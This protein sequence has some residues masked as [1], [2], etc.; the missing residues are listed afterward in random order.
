MKKNYMTLQRVTKD[1]EF[2]RNVICDLGGRKNQPLRSRLKR[3]ILKMNSIKSNGHSL[4]MTFIPTNRKKLGK[5][6]AKWSLVPSPIEKVLSAETLIP[7]QQRQDQ[8]QLQQLQSISN[9]KL[10]VTGFDVGV[11]NAVAWSSIRPDGNVSFGTASS[12]GFYNQV[13]QLFTLDKF[14]LFH[15]TRSFKVFQVF[16]LEAT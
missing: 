14:T 2:F 13:I 10:T 8:L 12:K 7:K 15:Q 5:F 3:G 16:R 11:V 1:G 6:E 9:V 4:Q